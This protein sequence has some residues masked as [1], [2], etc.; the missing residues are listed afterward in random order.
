V[1]GIACN[2]EAVVP[3]E[4]LSQCRKTVFDGLG[5]IILVVDAL[6]A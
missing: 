3:I 6:R 5:T 1:L 2:E 4:S